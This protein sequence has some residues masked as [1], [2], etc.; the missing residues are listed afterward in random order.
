M[1]LGQLWYAIDREL[2]ADV[3]IEEIELGD[4][5]RRDSDVDDEGSDEVDPEALDSEDDAED[6]EIGIDK[7]ESEGTHVV[8]ISRLT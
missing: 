6:D 7:E 8:W 4:T 1:F 5:Q 3:E 2:S